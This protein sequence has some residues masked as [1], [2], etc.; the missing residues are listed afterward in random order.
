MLLPVEE[1]LPG[2]CLPPHLSPFVDHAEASYIPPEKQRMINLKLGIVDE[3]PKPTTKSTENTVKKTENKIVS[4]QKSEPKKL[5]EK[6]KPLAVEEDDQQLGDHGMRVDID[7]PGE[8]SV[9][10]DTEISESEEEDKTQ[11]S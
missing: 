9:D 11:V 8:E 5:A 7:S 3:T 6:E 2:A 4:S 10:E 1:Y